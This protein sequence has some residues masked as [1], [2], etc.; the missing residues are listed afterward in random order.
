[1]SQWTVALEPPSDRQ[2]RAFGHQHRNMSATLS[3]SPSLKV[4]AMTS[5]NSKAFLLNAKASM[6]GEASE[7]DGFR[8]SKLSASFLRL[9]QWVAI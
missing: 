4:D 7:F 9:G 8:A 3:L 1:M 6:S 5:N 2:K